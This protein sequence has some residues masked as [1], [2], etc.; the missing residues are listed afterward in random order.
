MGRCAF[1]FLPPFMSRNFIFLMSFTSR[2]ALLLAHAAAYRPTMVS[3]GFVRAP[4]PWPWLWSS[5]ETLAR[6]QC[7][8]LP[9]PATIV[10]TMASPP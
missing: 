4:R 6:S 3:Q 2:L 9:L 7:H 10:M 1:F 8:I 5:G